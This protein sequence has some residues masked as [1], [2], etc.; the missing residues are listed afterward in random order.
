MRNQQD[1]LAGVS[2]FF[3]TFKASRVECDVTNRENLVQQQNIRV[4]VSGDGEAQSDEHARRISLHW[5]IQRIANF[6]EFD[7]AGSLVVISRWLIP[8]IAPLRYTF[9]RPVRSG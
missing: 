5:R 3:N 2:Q 8:M 7:N 1:G 9:S 6:S 4:K